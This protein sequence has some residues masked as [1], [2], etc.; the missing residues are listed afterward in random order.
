[1]SNP[2]RAFTIRATDVGATNG[3]HYTFTTPTAVSH[4]LH[5]NGDCPA[6][7]AHLKCHEFDIPTVARTDHGTNPRTFTLTITDSHP[8]RGHV[9][10]TKTVTINP[11]AIQRQ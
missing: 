8:L 5:H 2:S 10:A 4:R 1:M 9:S 6:P 11:P 3:T 7:D